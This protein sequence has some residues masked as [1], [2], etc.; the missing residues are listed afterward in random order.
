MGEAV[1]KQDW[2]HSDRAWRGSKR[3]ILA[4]HIGGWR[5]GESPLEALARALG[6]DTE[7][8]LL[9]L[10]DPWMERHELN[11]LSGCLGQGWAESSGLDIEESVALAISILNEKLRDV[12]LEV[13]AFFGAPR[14]L[15]PLSSMRRR[16]YL[17][18]DAG[19][20]ARM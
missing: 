13:R 20:A 5:S 1:S 8:I 3:A 11:E 18:R 6:V 10:P 19:V 17:D 2:A 15:E 4:Y 9:E 16:L 7:D 12:P 14:K